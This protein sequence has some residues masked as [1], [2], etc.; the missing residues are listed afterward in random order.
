MKSSHQHSGKTDEPAPQNND[1][2]Q[3]ESRNAF[4]RVQDFKSDKINEIKPFTKGST[5]DRVHQTDVIKKDEQENGLDG[6]P[7]KEVSEFH[8]MNLMLSSYDQNQT[9]V[10]DQSKY[11]AQSSNHESLVRT[12]LNEK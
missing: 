10:N 4:I 9:N 11:T 3:Q 7:P 6:F 8:S 5:L 12:L 1:E 2:S